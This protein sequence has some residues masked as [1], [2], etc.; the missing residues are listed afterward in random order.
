MAVL[1]QGLFSRFSGALLP[2]HLDE[3]DAKSQPCFDAL[4]QA[5]EHVVDQIYPRLR[6]LPKYARRLSGP[7]LTTFRHIDEMIEK[8]PGAVLCSRSA[9]MEDPRVNAFF[10]D[11]HHLEEVFSQSAEVRTLFDTHPE[12]EECWALLCLRKEERRQ[13]GLSLVGDKV[14]RDVMQ[15]SVSFTD[16]QVVSPSTSEADARRSFKCRLFN[17]LLDFIRNRAGTARTT[18]MELEHRVKSLKGRLRQ[19]TRHKGG[20]LSDDALIAQIAQLERAIQQQDLRLVSLADYLEFVIDVLGSPAQILSSSFYSIRL[21]RLGILLEEDSLDPGY[22]VPLSEIRLT[23]Q[24]PKVGSLVRFPRA[25][26]LAPKT[27]W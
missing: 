11:P 19:T 2:A 27:P 26:L 21:S 20:N 15:T 24:E 4:T 17:R 13:P 6:V 16:H 9:F 5:V 7:V 18:T 1:L 10:V 25:E 12:A 3:D 23:T 14:H 8:V 22:E